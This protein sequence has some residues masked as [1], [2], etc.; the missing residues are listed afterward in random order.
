MAK[1]LERRNC[2]QYREVVIYY[3]SHMNISGFADVCR[4]EKRSNLVMGVQI[5][6]WL[7][8]TEDSE[9]SSSREIA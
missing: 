4:I 2:A 3:R 7:T 1:V 5:S 9:V 8:G 6:L